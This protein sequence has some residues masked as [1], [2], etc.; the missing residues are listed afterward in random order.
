MRIMVVENGV[1]SVLV[2][3]LVTISF[4]LYCIGRYLVMHRM[5]S[6]LNNIIR[7]QALSDEHVQFL[8]YQI[9][10]GLKVG[11]YLLGQACPHIY[12]TICALSAVCLNC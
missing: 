9:M 2:S 11:P 6:D 3:I 12:V 10:R 7:Q 5:G 8:V 4:V 1:F